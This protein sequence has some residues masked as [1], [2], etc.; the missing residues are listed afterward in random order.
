MATRTGVRIST[1][2]GDEGTALTL[3]CS[4]ETEGSMMARLRLCLC[5]S[6]IENISTASFGGK[7]LNSAQVVEWLSSSESHE[8]GGHIDKDRREDRGER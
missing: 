8:R 6:K 7:I 5:A 2:I 3:A 1:S 4:E